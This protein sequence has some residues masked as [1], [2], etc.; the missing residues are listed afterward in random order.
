MHLMLFQRNCRTKALKLRLDFPPD[1]FLPQ[2]SSSSSSSSFS[3]L[4]RRSLTEVCAGQR[5]IHEGQHRVRLL[6]AK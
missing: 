2:S 3:I 1:H 6:T 5:D 4:D